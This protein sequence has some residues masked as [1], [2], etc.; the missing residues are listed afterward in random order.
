MAGRT[1]GRRAQDIEK[2]LEVLRLAVRVSNECDVRHI[3]V[4]E[5][6]SIGERVAELL[7]SLAFEDLMQFLVIF[8][9]D[10]PGPLMRQADYWLWQPYLEDLMTDREARARAILPF[11]LPALP[12]RVR[13]QA[14]QPNGCC[15]RE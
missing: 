2:L 15:G 11:E 12:G 13:G 10:S 8:H 1:P 5:I 3:A 4:D 14:R 7:I 6:C 9:P